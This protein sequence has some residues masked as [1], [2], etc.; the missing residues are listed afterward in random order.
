[1]LMIRKTVKLHAFSTRVSICHTLNTRLFR[2][3]AKDLQ[4]ITLVLESR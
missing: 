2:N 1:M 4:P 3:L